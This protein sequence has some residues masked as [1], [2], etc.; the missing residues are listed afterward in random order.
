MSGMDGCQTLHDL[1]RAA[2]CGE[3]FAIHPIP[4]RRGPGLSC[5]AVAVA[6]V[7]EVIGMFTLPRNLHFSPAATPS[8]SAIA[9]IRAPKIEMNIRTRLRLIALMVESA[10]FGTLWTEGRARCATKNPEMPEATATSTKVDGRAMAARAANRVR[11]TL[12]RTLRLDSIRRD[13][14]ALMAANVGTFIMT[15]MA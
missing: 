1:H 2:L 5:S 14:A 6:P 9:S 10:P 3:S 13:S 8:W 7:A 4:C 12:C 11:S 15:L